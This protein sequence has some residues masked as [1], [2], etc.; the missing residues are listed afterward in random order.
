MNH[1][2]RAW[3]SVIS[4]HRRPNFFN[5]KRCEIISAPF[6]ID[7]IV[8]FSILNLSHDEFYGNKTMNATE[9]VNVRAPGNLSLPHRRP[10]QCQTLDISQHQPLI[11]LGRYPQRSSTHHNN[12]DETDTKT[13]K[14]RA[15]LLGE[16]VFEVSSSFD[17]FRFWN[18][19]KKTLHFWHVTVEFVRYENNSRFSRF[20]YFCVAIRYR[21]CIVLRL[22]C[23]WSQC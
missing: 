6:N 3:R 23:T 11:W 2:F 5:K 1:K 7:G 19:V 8:F 14:I 18:I 4:S 10:V 21:R 13:L 22:F 15:G 9:W 17:C 20:V 16:F 12:F